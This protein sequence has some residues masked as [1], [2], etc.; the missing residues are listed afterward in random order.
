MKSVDLCFE[1]GRIV[2]F[3]LTKLISNRAI[4]KTIKDFGIIEMVIC[5]ITTGGPFYDILY[6]SNRSIVAPNFMP[7]VDFE[8]EYLYNFLCSKSFN[9]SDENNILLHVFELHDFCRKNKVFF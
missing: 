8:N 1:D 7:N 6:S 4:I 5:R 9:K 2:N 3:P